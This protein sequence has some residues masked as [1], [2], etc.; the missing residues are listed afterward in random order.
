MSDEDDDILDLRKVEDVFACLEAVAMA[1]AVL[2]GVDPDTA[3]GLEKVTEA[4]GA[5]TLVI[6]QGELVQQVEK[7][8]EVEK[9]VEKVVEVPVPASAQSP[10]APR[11]EKRGIDDLVDFVNASKP[12]SSVA[13]PRP[14]DEEDDAII[15]ILTGERVR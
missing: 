9:V 3:S 11:E 6:E 8:V 15:D 12:Q 10:P 5:L 4:L 13:T 2:M 1:Q 14:A 7:I